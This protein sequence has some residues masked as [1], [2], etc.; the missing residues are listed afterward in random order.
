MPESI[1]ASAI[2]YGSITAAGTD[3][4][5]L[6]V[7]TA[8][9]GP[10]VEAALSLSATRGYRLTRGILD[11]ADSEEQLLAE[12][13]SLV[14]WAKGADS[15]ARQTV[16]RAVRVQGGE[17]FVVHYVSGM[18]RS[19]ARPFL[20]DFFDAGGTVRAVAQWLQAAGEA[21]AAVD[22]KEDGTAGIFGDVV[23]WVKDTAEDAVDTVREGVETI[24]DAVESAGKAIGDVIGEAAPW[25]KDKVGD[26]IDALEEAG[27]NLGEIL[28]AAAGESLDLLE[29]FVEAAIEA[30]KT[31]GDVLD[32][33]VDQAGDRL[34]A[35]IRALHDRAE[36]ASLAEHLAS[37][38]LVGSP[39][40]PIR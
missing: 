6:D 20:S 39:L 23:D 24:V 30:G 15:Q 12:T 37:Y 14:A 13:E 8:E 16:S 3:F 33:A 34:R 5:S 10:A 25:A 31:I 19:D 4:R 22:A 18:A 40:Q 35:A 2:N 32:W 36:T 11:T 29:K 17:P 7:D 26:L 1:D 27:K 38:R 9:V 28:A 21:L